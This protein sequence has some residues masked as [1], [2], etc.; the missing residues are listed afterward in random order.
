MATL[1]TE[2][3]LVHESSY[4]VVSRKAV[5]AVRASAGADDK[6]SFKTIAALI[7]VICVVALAPAPWSMVGVVA[8]I[9]LTLELARMA[10][11]KQK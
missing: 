8:T 11:R 1:E 10:W 7:V 2:T 4:V 3:P 5:E 6:L 9:I